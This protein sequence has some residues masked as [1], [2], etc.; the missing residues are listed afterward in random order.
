MKIIN[1]LKSFIDGCFDFENPSA[2]CCKSIGAIPGI[3]KEYK[4]TCEKDEDNKQN[5]DD[6]V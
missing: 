4:R 6:T 1:K 3:Q 5:K 2:G